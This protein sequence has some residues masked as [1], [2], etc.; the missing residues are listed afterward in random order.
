MNKLHAYFVTFCVLSVFGFFF[1]F[2]LVTVLERAFYDGD[3]FT[4]DYFFNI[5]VSPIYRN[6]LFNAL[7][8]GICSTIIAFLIAYPLASIAHRFHFPLKRILT[9]LILIPLVLPPFV[10]AIGIKEMLGANGALNAFLVSLGL[11]S[12]EDPIHWLGKDRFIGVV[13]MNALHLYPILYLNII[14]AFRNLDPLMEQA[15][16][17]LG[18]TT[19]TRFRKITLPLCIPSIFAGG[20]VVFIWAFTELGVPLIFDY[21]TIT[22]VQIFQGLHSLESNPMPFAL[23]SVMLILSCIFFLCSRFFLRKK[24]NVSSRATRS[25]A[26]VKHLSWKNG[27]VITLLFS[28][29]FLLASIPHAG[30]FFFSV[31]QDWYQTVLPSSM[32]LDNYSDGLS[33]PLFVDSIANS[34]LY[35]TGATLIDLAAGLAIAWVLVRSTIIGR[36]V[37]DTLLMLPIAVPGVVIAFGYFTMCQPG[38]PF[39]FLIKLGGGPALMLIIA[40]SI[41]RLPYLVRSAVAGLQQTHP[42]LEEAARTMGAT[43]ISMLRRV[44]IPLVVANLLAGCILAFSFAMLEVSDSLM[45]AHDPSNY[46]V[47]KAIYSVLS[48]LGNGS[49]MAAALGLWVIIFLGITIIGAMSLVGRKSA[50]L[51]RV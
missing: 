24:F 3:R 13:I 10:G 21:N 20:V 5:A 32:T 22:S 19:F 38:E 45:I 31:S 28:I 43:P 9:V 39:H 41:R 23:V 16:Y 30:V 46:P 40:Y 51:F 36:K 7:L 42:S 44:A 8:I 49:E 25:Y 37:I 14:A 48:S 34:L 12:F 47:T 4:Y 29:V 2:P 6:G 17:N 15:A 50:I 11:I 26:S 35:S 18:A 1:L 27:G 33:H